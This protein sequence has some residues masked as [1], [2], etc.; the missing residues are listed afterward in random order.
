VNMVI[1][2]LRN[3]ENHILWPAGHIQHD[4]K[5]RLGGA[6][7]LADI[8][9]AVPEA[10]VVRVRT[11]RLWGSMFSYAQTAEHPSLIGRYAAGLGWLLANLLVFMPRRPVDVT[12]ERVDHDQLPE[13]R[14]ETLNP[15]LEAWYNENG[16]PETPTYV[17]YHFV[18]GRR[19]FE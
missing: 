17:P 15:W 6:R 12:I 16:G 18:F 5:E 2:G 13:L 19:T 3:G 11:R 4:G 14:R 1:D 7:A 8:L 9:Q 10:T